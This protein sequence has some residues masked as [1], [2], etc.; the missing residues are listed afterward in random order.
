MKKLDVKLFRSI[1]NTKGQF[2][3]V[4]ILIILALTTYVSLNMVADN[5]YDSMI[6]YYEDT[7]FGHIFVQVNRIPQ[8]SIDKLSSIEGIELAQGRISSDVPLR[9]EDPNEK[10]NVRIVSLP[11]EEIRINDLYLEAGEMIDD[12]P[13]TTVVLKQFFNGRNMEL[14]QSLIPY[15]GGSEYPLE[16]TGVVG[17]PE[18]VYLME[19][20]QTLMPSEDKFG[21]LYVT[22]EFAQMIFGYGGNYNEVMITVAED[23]FS[24]IDDIKDQV[25]DELDRYGVRQI[26]TRDE[27]LSHTVMMQ[28]IDSVAIMSQSVTFVFLIVA[29]IIINIMLSR[30]VKRDR[31]S[32]GVMKAMG[33]LNKDI[34]LHYV[35]Y[36]FIIGLSGSILGGLFSTLVSRYM[37]ELFIEFFNVP[38]FTMK[39]DYS[40]LINGIVLTSIFCIISGLIGARD[41]IKILPADSMMPEA[42]KSGKRIWLE[43]IKW[44]WNKASFSWKVVIRNIFRNKRRALFLVFGIATT[45]AITMI[46]IYLSTIF[47]SMFISQFED[48]QTMDYNLDFT[49]PL[50][51][52]VLLEVSKIID[53]DYIEPK[54]EM[55]L[56]LRHGWKEETVNTIAI[57]QDSKMYNF[58]DLE[59]KDIYLKKHGIFLSEIL[60]KQ[61][62]VEVGDTILVDNYLADSEEEYIEVSGIVQQYIG[63]NAYMNIEQMYELLDEKDMVTG[64]LINSEDEVISKLKDI[65]NIRQIQTIDD[66]KDSILEYMDMIILSIGI[67]LVFAGALGF[68]IVYNITSVSINERTMEFSSLRV[69]GFEKKQ[70]YRLVTRENGIMAILGIIIGIPL[71]YSMCTGMAESVSTEIYIIPAF[72]ETSTYLYAGIITIIFVVIAQLATIRKIHD[73]NFLEALKN[74]VS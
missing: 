11:D 59:N 67:M 16:I 46:P 52:K 54:V 35:K 26:I 1:K 29:A 36:A 15:I 50:D 6:Q 32:I 28:E 48:F 68:A 47:D 41:V 21:V 34:M 37:T 57:I 64:A 4:T 44:F 7:N 23:Y 30:I 19:S 22:E 56:I 69:M 73:I 5:L 9:V 55:P 58:K 51:E 38:L 14:D 42:P 63:S 40:Y 20:E 53:E 62:E 60:A 74:R 2:I 39:I 25:E 65:K 17:S 70:I 18:Y 8:T 49:R 10:V 61:L 27:Q 3:S 13:R 43:E 66:M 45:Y 31:M 72:V 24:K 33:Y 71:G 12:N